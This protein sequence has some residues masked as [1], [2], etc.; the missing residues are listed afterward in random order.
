MRC[1]GLTTW[2]SFPWGLFQ[3][4]CSSFRP[5]SQR[6]LRPLLLTLVSMLELCLHLPSS[7]EKEHPPVAKASPGPVPG[8]LYY[9]CPSFVHLVSRISLSFDVISCSP[10]AFNPIYHEYSTLE[11]SSGP[12]NPGPPHCLA[13]PSGGSWDCRSPIPVSVL[14]AQSPC[15]LP[16]CRTLG[17]ESDP[18]FKTQF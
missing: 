18:L 12:C 6:K 11:A 15:I 5:A 17:Q 1:H 2:V 3:T 7:P 13:V 16:S 4:P 14:A 9:C 8:A 10:S